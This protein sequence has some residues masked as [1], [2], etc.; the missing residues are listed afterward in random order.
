M[1]RSTKLAFDW[2]I[3][4]VDHGSMSIMHVA[5]GLLAISC[6]SCMRLCKI[7]IYS[8]YNSA[9]VCRNIYTKIIYIYHYWN[10]YTYIQMYI[11]VVYSTNRIK[12]NRIRQNMIRWNE[13]RQKGIRSIRLTDKS[14]LL[15]KKCYLKIY[16]LKNFFYKS[17]E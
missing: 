9:Q 11:V 8:T 12:R 4:C 3:L 6:I 17:W 5:N 7:Y 16:I 2:L 10:I 15:N 1:L 13:N 14:N